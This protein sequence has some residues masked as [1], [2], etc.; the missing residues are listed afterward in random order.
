MGFKPKDN[1]GSRIMQQQEVV[2]SQEQFVEDVFNDDY[3]LVVGSEVIMDRQEEPSGDVNQY[4]LRALN[5]SLGR[6]YKDFNELVTRSGEGIDAIRNLLNSKEDW[7]YDLNDV[8]PE[9]KG[10]MVRK[11]H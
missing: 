5:S 1:T 3:V 6:D 2:F 8:S 11:V 9:L 10:L 4:I 7:S